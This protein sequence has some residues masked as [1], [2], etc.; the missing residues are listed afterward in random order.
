MEQQPIEIQKLEKNFR[1][2]A[3]SV[4]A[5]HWFGPYIVS[6]GRSIDTSDLPGLVAIQSGKPV[7]LLT[8][9]ICG[10]A[11]ELVT[12]NALEQRSGI[13]S[14]L[15]QKLKQIAGQRGCVCIRL[16]T[17]N[18]NM[19]ALRFYQRHGFV[20]TALHRDALEE[21]RKLKAQIPTTGIDGI[22]LRDELE[23]EYSITS[24]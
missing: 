5:E 16:V 21:S 22:P 20:L 24:Q 9:Q 1:E 18:D 15:I 23:L 8:Y 14:Q 17:T 2:W 6:R 13:G 11:C 19:H 10:N 7:G 12:L 4:I 3:Q